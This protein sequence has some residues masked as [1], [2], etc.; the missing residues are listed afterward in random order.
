VRPGAI[1][2]SRTDSFS[3]DSSGI[4]VSRSRFVDPALDTGGVVEIYPIRH[5]LMRAEAGNV[6]LFYREKT[7]IEQGQPAKI[8][9]SEHASMLLLFGAGYRF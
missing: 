9:G 4:K 5:F 1:V 2:F 6:S 7:V 3:I 8:P